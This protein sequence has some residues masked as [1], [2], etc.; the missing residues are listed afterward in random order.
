MFVAGRQPSIVPSGCA[1]ACRRSSSLVP[2]YAS[3]AACI[4]LATATATATSPPPSPSLT[5]VVDCDLAIEMFEPLFD[6]S[7]LCGQGI[8]H[9]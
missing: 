8:Q 4:T 7:D 2:G 5:T 3:D 6:S 9:V 1:I